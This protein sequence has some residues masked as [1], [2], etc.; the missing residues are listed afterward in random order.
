MHLVGGNGGDCPN[1]GGGGGGAGGGDGN[2]QSNKLPAR[3]GGGAG[4]DRTSTGRGGEGGRSGYRS[5]IINFDWFN[6]EII[7]VKDM[8]VF[9]SI[10][11]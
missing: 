9:H 2:T 3:S 7:L 1:D 8:V 11:L 6:L 5:D 10:I 4:R